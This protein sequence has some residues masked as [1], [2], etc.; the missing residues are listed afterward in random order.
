MLVHQIVHVCTQVDVT[1]SL[2]FELKVSPSVSISLFSF[3]NI[4]HLYLLENTLET[5]DQAGISHRLGKAPC[6]R[7]KHS[8][9]LL[10][11]ESL[12]NTVKSGEVGTAVVIVSLQ[13]IQ[14]KPK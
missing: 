2:M 14:I 11:R 12:G 7:G 4:H 10:P 5:V 8:L 1:G 9:P 3:Y 13:D 6:L